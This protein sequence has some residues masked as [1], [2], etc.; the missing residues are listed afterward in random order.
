MKKIFPF[1]SQNIL[2]AIQKI[3]DDPKLLKRRTSFEYDLIYKGKTYPPIL[4]LSEANKVLGGEELL[5]SDFNNSTQSA[6]RIFEDLGFEVSKKIKTKIWIEKT[7]VHGRPDREVGERALGK[8]LWSP[9]KD[10]RGADIYKNMREVKAGDIVLHLIDNK[11]FTGVSIVKNRVIET[12]GL[13][14]T[15]WTGPAY[16]VELIDFVYLSPPLN[17]TEIFVRENVTELKSISEGSEVFYNNKFDLR[18]G[19]YLTPC[20]FRLYNLINKT[21]FKNHKLNLPYSDKIS[22]D[23]GQKEIDEIM[24]L[25]KQLSDSTLLSIKTKPFILLAGF[26][27]TG[28]SRLVRS[29]AYKF[30]NIDEDK[31]SI[32]HPPTNFQLIKVKPN[33]HDSSDLLGYESRISGKDR[34]IV[35]DFIR[36]IV[37]AHQYPDTPF[38]LCLDEMNL[39]PVEQYFAEY[40]SVIETRVI[41]DETGSAITT[42]TIISNT[43]FKK[44]ADKTDGVDIAFD[45]WKELE[46]TDEKTQEELKTKGLTLPQNLI[47]MGTV[48]MDETT[49]SFSRKVL[50]RAM[51]LEMN[52]I[53]LSAGLD[54]AANEWSYSDNPVPAEYILSEKTHGYQVYEDIKEDADKIIKYLETLNDKLEGSPFK[55]AYRVRDEFLLY[56][57]NYNKIEDKPSDWLTKVIDQMTI[58]K[59]LPRIEG[60]EDRT[61]V[62]EDLLIIF[63]AYSLIG[64]VK[65]AEEMEKRRKLYHY[66]SFWS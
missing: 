34:F 22:F 39:A 3:N 14:N 31:L 64:S 32:K 24:K 33:W 8:A 53:D 65:K 4:V 23:Q 66:T 29:L 10:K 17:R 50:D 40:L 38:F 57:F 37:K 21:Y 6:F 48:N 60:D 63:G 2:H 43:M 42:D 44:Y 49:H 35:T 1:T 41:N 47:V 30:N 18:Q 9:K 28:K 59:I 61:K 25:K 26:S 13:H 45:L 46:L 19:A 51:T 16:L 52:E 12:S 20:P 54:I 55:I 5:L 7:L 62:L 15:D 58:M 11:E 56:A 36:F 27:G